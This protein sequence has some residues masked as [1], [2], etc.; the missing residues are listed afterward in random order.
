[1]KLKSVSKLIFLS[2]LSMGVINIA[3][4]AQINQSFSISANIKGETGALE[5]EPVGGS[6][7]SNVTFEWDEIGADFRNPDLVYFTVKSNNITTVSLSSLTSLESG[8]AVIPVDVHIRPQGD[9]GTYAEDVDFTQKEIYNNCD[10]VINDS[11]VVFGIQLI[12]DKTDMSDELGEIILDGTQPVGG[13]YIGSV[14]LIFESDVENG[15]TVCV[16]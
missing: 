3:N 2:V 6:W 15:G 14:D 16:G 12:A 7:P 10:L 8:L 11:A 1:M 4:S 5:V 9:E 13:Q